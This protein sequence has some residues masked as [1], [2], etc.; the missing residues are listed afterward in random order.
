MDPT[1]LMSYELFSVSAAFFDDHGDM[2]L[3]SSKAT[4]KNALKVETARRTQPR[5]INVI[6]LDGCALLWV[7]PWPPSGSPVQDFLDRFRKYLH[8]RLLQANVFLV[9][10]HYVQSSTKYATR[11]SRENKSSRMYT[12]TNTTRLPAVSCSDCVKEQSS[13]D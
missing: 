5:S 4:L 12:L 11:A 9:F 6:V 1:T 7:I 13:T 3:T 10:D 2:R 8:K